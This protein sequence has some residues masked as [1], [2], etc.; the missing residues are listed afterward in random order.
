MTASRVGVL[1][2][3]ETHLTEQR[4]ADLHKMFANRIKIFASPHPVS[5]TQKEGVAVVLNKKI[6]NADGAK[7]TEIIPGRAIQLSLPWRGGDVRELLCVYAPTTEG[8]AERRAFFQNLRDYYRA[9]P[10]MRRPDLMA[11]DFNN[12]EDALDRSPATEGAVDGSVQDLDDL[13]C[14]LGLMLVDGWRATYPDSR[15]YTFHRDAGGI[16][17]LSRLDRIYVSAETARWTREW[18]IE[19]VGVRTDHSMVSV[20]LT[21]PNAPEMGKGRP[22]FPL[23]LLRDRKLADGMKRRGVEV[24]QQIE[25]IARNGR[26]DACNP[27]TVL[28]SLKKDWL[29]MARRREKETVPKLLREIEL[30]E[31][32]LKE[33]AGDSGRPPGEQEAELLALTKQLQLLKMKRTKQ[34]QGS[35]RAKHR[36][37]GERPTKY[38]TKLHREQAPRELITAFEKEGVLSPQGEKLYEAN[39][40]KMAEMARAHY[41]GIQQDGE[42]VTEP[43]RREADIEAALST[44]LKTVDGDQRTM[45]G[46]E[47]SWADCELALH[48]A[49]SGTAPGLDGIQYEV[50]KTLHAR[51]VEDSRHEGRT[52]LDVVKLLTEAM[53]DIQRHG[54]CGA[55]NFAEGW[56]SPIYKEKGERT[57]VVNYRP[58]TLL[59]TDYKLLSKVLAIRLA[60]VAP[61]V[62][63]EAQAGFV[64]GRRLRNHTQLAKMMIMW[65][66]AKDVNGVIVALDQEKAYDKIAHDYLWRVLAK[67]G[68]PES[69]ISLIQTLYESAVTSVVIN[70][71]T[72]KTYRIFRGVRQGD[73]LS[74]LLFDLAIEPLSAMIR[75]SPLK[76]FEL[77]DGGSALKATLFAD[78]T[79]V[80]LAEGDDFRVLQAILD[81][82]CSAAKAKFNIKKTEVIPLGKKAFR[83]ALVDEYSRTGKWR[84]LPENVHVAKDGDA[85]RILGAFMGNE[86]DQGAVWSAKVEKVRLVLERWKASRSTAVGKKHAVQM[87]LGGMTQFLTDVQRMPSRVTKKLTKMM[88]DFVWDDKQYVPIAT[89][90]LFLE[91]DEGG[92]GL[93]DLEARND[94]IDLMWLKD[95]LNLGPTRQRWAYL[96][97]DLLAM[98]AVKSGSL[99][100]SSSR[101]NMFLQH[102][103]PATRA[104]PSDLKAMVTVARKYGVRQEGI[105]FSRVIL[106]AMPMWDHR[107]AGRTE[108]GRL[109]ARSATTRCLKFNHK[110]ATVGDFE[111][112][113]VILGEQAHSPEAECTCRSCEN[114]IAVEGCAN[115]HRCCVRAGKLLD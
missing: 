35:S 106:R 8:V 45:L 79:T 51:F 99:W 40:E 60:A 64:P 46:A 24:V 37:D 114:L 103:H 29:D 75:E 82:W 26:T 98:H 5:P 44:I 101:V 102:W 71:V 86:V 20:L 85:V 39:P 105:A 43:G 9:R 11:G 50:W 13:K 59:N 42:D 18:R 23:H 109:S 107:H 80:Y 33:A 63:H 93:L 4:R 78:D 58:I 104:L 74:C 111:K 10:A 54:V 32:R 49:K 53:L 94:A 62:V 28:C 70:G 56:M 55:T 25:E 34:L 61:D 92:I 110:A 68:L 73:P 17:S 48:F 41:D 112:L 47:I 113:A 31:S 83:T 2:L 52:R 90:H 30:L 96:A 14:E 66:E 67:F 6:I 36:E 84:H 57:K 97:D 95:Y 19:P 69:F 100:P 77:P 7:M 108:L 87:M 16:R 88:R 38:W 12:V 21:T 15:E 115:P 3:Q 1:L 65:A 27:Q 22:V 81:T 72:S 89:E 76:G 91:S